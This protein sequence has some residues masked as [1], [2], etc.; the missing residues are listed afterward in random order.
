[1]REA[2]EELLASQYRQIWQIVVDLLDKLVDLL[3]EEILSVRDYADVLEEGF[4]S[5]KKSVRFRREQTVILGDIENE[6]VWRESRCCFS[7]ASMTDDSESTANG[8]I[9]VSI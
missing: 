7:W 4:A 1:M 3:G 6:P 8:G 9:F 5:A 2:G